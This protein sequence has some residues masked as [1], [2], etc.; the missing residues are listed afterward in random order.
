MNFLQKFFLKHYIAQSQPERLREL[1]SLKSCSSIG[2]MCEITDEDSYKEI[3][4]VF[5]QLQKPGRNLW[6]MGYVDE[7]SVP[8]YCLQQLTADFFCKKDFNW[9]GKPVK[10]QVTD[11]LQKEFDLLIDFTTR[12]LA[13]MAMMLELSN[14]RCIVGGNV[15]HEE[16]YDLFLNMQN[17]FSQ[18]DL[19]QQ[20]DIYTQKL[21]GED[22]E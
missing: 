17:E 11:Y 2:L 9:Y 4:Q 8:F 12:S 18:L 10:V 22:G 6:L 7:K 3:M 16:Y 14:A 13:P 5:A 20:V 15:E 19:L 21:T 1:C